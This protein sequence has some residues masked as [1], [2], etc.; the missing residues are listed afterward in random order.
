MIINS[1]I[2]G[3]NEIGAAYLDEELLRINAK[4]FK[5]DYDEAL[6]DETIFDENHI[7]PAL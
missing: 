7:V 5:D 2:S 6:S 1:V 3:I 4:E